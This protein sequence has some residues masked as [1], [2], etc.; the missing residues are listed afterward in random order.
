MGFS[1][2]CNAGGLASIP[3]MGRSPG[4]GDSNPLQY[5]CLENPMNI[6]AW[7]ATVHG[8]AKSWTQLSNFTFTFIIAKDKLSPHK[9]KTCPGCC[10]TVNPAV[11][12]AHAM[13]RRPREAKYLVLGSLLRKRVVALSPAP[14]ALLIH[15]LFSERC[16]VHWGHAWDRTKEAPALIK[17]WGKTISEQPNA[18]IRQFQEV[19]V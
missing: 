7:W 15:Q 16:C 3:G 8:V 17:V 11:H 4:E 19:I 5:S 6:G 1:S 10:L 14:F 13:Q 9:F 12:C 2:A 18:Q